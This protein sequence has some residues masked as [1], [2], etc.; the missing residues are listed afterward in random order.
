MIKNVCMYTHKMGYYAVTKEKSRFG[1]ADMKR[2][3]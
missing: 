3:P 2:W 1:S